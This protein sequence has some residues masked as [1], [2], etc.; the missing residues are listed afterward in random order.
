HFAELSGPTLVKSTDFEYQI[1]PD[2]RLSLLTAATVTSYDL[3][4]SGIYRSSSLPPVTFGYTTFSPQQQRY[5]SIESRSNAM[6]D[7]ALSHSRV[8][9][10]DLFGDGLPDVLASGPDG[11]RYWRNLGEGVLDRP[12]L[13]PN[14]PSAIALNQAGV[15]LGDI[16]GDGRT[17]LLVHS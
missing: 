13:L 2:T 6:P 12:R 5:Q 17:D 14:V 11:F 4:S 10:V 1:D 7:I 16:G 15:G 9:L 3:D 8:A